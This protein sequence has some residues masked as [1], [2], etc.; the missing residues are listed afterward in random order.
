MSLVNTK[1]GLNKTRQSLPYK[2]YLDCLV[3]INTQVQDIY[4]NLK[5]LS[6]SPAIK[7]LEEEI[8]LTV[9]DL[10]TQFPGESYSQE[11]KIMMNYLQ[12]LPGGK[13]SLNE[14]FEFVNDKTIRNWTQPMLLGNLDITTVYVTTSVKTDKI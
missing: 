5:E 8:R 10:K 12:D 6:L 1:I 14:V 11:M 13:I 3:A 9:S 2:L 7:N 4:L